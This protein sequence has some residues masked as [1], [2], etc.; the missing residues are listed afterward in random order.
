MNNVSLISQ[1][2]WR[3]QTFSMDKVV[4]LPEISALR[5]AHESEQEPLLPSVEDKVV[6]GLSVPLDVNQII[7]FNVACSKGD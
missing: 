2:N 4:K 7:D 3:K 1:E 6:K 5:G